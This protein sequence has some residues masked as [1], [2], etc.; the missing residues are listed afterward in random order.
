MWLDRRVTALNGD[1]FTCLMTRET[2]F[3]AKTRFGAQITDRSDDV[4]RP[5]AVQ[6]L[7]RHTRARTG[8]NCGVGELDC[9]LLQFHDRRLPH[10]HCKWPLLSVF[11]QIIRELIAYLNWIVIAIEHCYLTGHWI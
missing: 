4:T 2:H 8:G 1:C 9:S 7:R 6:T 3:N 10:Q 11:Q 5:V